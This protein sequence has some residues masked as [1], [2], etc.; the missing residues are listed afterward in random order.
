MKIE[1]KKFDKNIVP[2]NKRAYL[3]SSITARVLTYLFCV[4][5]SIVIIF[6]LLITITSAFK[7]GNNMSFALDFSK[8]WTLSNFTKLFSDTLYLRWYINTLLIAGFAMVLQVSIVT[9]AG[10]VYSRFKFPGR[11]N[12]L[13]AFLIIQMVPTTAALVAFYV[14]GDMV[15]GINQF[16]YLTLIYVGGGIPMNTWLMKGYFDSV[17]ISLDESAKLDGA[18]NFKIFFKILLPLVKPMIAVQ[19]LWAFL[20]PFGEFMLAKFILTDKSSFTVAV[21]LQ[22]FISDSHNMR[23]TMFAAGALLIA[24]PVS[25]LFFILQKNFVSGLLSGGTKG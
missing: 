1:E 19:A 21:G 22:S 17:P 14:L 3:D 25:V 18:S 5:L 16:W 11:K 4:G 6:P 23:V 12:S 9:L 7:P 8:G 2:K 24:I 15:G 13:V 20:N 10:Y